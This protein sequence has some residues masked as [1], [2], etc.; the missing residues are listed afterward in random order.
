MK[1]NKTL[2][3]SLLSLILVLSVA[4]ACFS[5]ACGKKNGNEGG[6]TP[7]PVD[8]P[9][10]TEYTD[11]E[12]TLLDFESPK[13]LY[14]V[15][16]YIEDI[17]DLYGKITV[18][19][20]AEQARSGKGFLKFAYVSGKN[21]SLVFYPAHSDYPDIPVERLASF[22]I[23]VFSTAEKDKK[24][25]LSIVSGSTAVYS[26]QKEFKP[27]WNDY[28]FELDPVL[29]KFRSDEI[30]AFCVGTEGGDA[31]DFYFD[32]WT[33]TIGEKE[34]TE[35][36][37]TA[38]SFAEEADKLKTGTPSEDTL[39]KAYGYYGKLDEACRSAVESY[40]EDYVKAVAKFLDAKSWDDAS[41]WAHF[42]EKYGILQLGETEGATYEYG[43]DAFGNGKGGTSLTFGGFE[44]H[45]ESSEK[46]PASAES[47]FNVGITTSTI[48]TDRYDY[49]EFDI[50]NE[51]DKDV[52]LC[53]N[54][55]SNAVTIPAGKTVKANLPATDFVE[56]GNVIT[57]TFNYVEGQ[58]E[59]AKIILST[60]SAKTVSRDNI[61][62]SAL[63]GGKYGGSGNVTISQS[64]GKYVADIK[65]AEAKISVNK[66]YN[67]INVSQ[68][69][70][71]S[72]V[73]DKT[74]TLS[75]YNANDELV[76]RYDV[77]E[78]ASVIIL[79]EDEYE[80]L[81]Y[82]K[83]SVAC[84]ITLSDMLLSRAVNNDYTEIILKNDYVVGAEELTA[85]N[86]R[87]AVYFLSSFESMVAYKQNRMKSDNADVYAD[88]TA[89]ATK[90]SEIFK[91]IV[92]K[93]EAGTASETEGMLIL[94]LSGTYS[95]LKTVTPFTD[96][97]RYAIDDAK[98][99]TLL[100]YKYTV[101]DFNDPM[102]TSKFVAD[103]K[104]V[105]WSGSIAVE[106]FD[107]GKKL[108]IGVR[109][110]LP[111]G[112]RNARRI[113]MTYDISS[114][115]SVLSG[116]DYI[117]WRFY[118]ANSEDATLFFINYGWSGTVA[119]F[120]LKANRWTEIKL[121]INDFKSAVS[122]V[123]FPTDPGDKFYVDNAYACSAEYVQ[124][125]IDAIPDAKDITAY[126][127]DT[128]NFA[129]TEY[130]KLSSLAK[131]K[132]DVTRLTQAE[133]ILARLPY[134]VFDMSK[135]GVLD[136]FTHPT[137]IPSYL[138]DGDFSIEEDETY[139]KVL[140]VNTTG[141]TG[142]SPVLYLGYLLDEG[143]SA[144]DYVTFS[145][146]NPRSVEVR[147]C[148]ITRGWGKLYYSTQ[149]KAN[150]WTEVTVPVSALVSGGYF[151]FAEVLKNETLSF[152]I[153]DMVA[154]GSSSVQY[155]ID[156]LP[157]AD[158]VVA[159]DVDAIMSARIYYDKL[160]DGAKS[161]VNADKLV[162]CENALKNID[163]KIFDMSVDGVL[164]KFVN[165][166]EFYDWAG[167]FSIET[168]ATY[169]K[170]LSINT[171]GTPKA[172]V[173][174]GY[175]LAGVDLSN[176]T[177]VTF[178]VYNPASKNLTFA[179]IKRGYEKA[180]AK[181]TLLPGEW[182]EI[183]MSATDFKSA[184]YFYFADLRDAPENAKILITDVIAHN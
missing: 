27:G 50:K 163:Y 100:K 87:E 155:M 124:S 95:L 121:A 30:I 140:S 6:D 166:N 9:E 132:V 76:T 42:S 181:A 70:L 179:V 104:W 113:W 161:K 17:L 136:K 62:E 137:D 115:S 178:K 130:E 35:V 172:V 108:A 7:G 157:D 79:S 169:G 109:K 54:G 154:Y 14:C 65:D 38:L 37:K 52:S 123:I 152:R 53:V 83:T 18:E 173:Y 138:W 1:R 171:S 159:S 41:A 36:Q 101:F 110:V 55:S 131:K 81:S 111:D 170:V 78:T 105:E 92:S 180:Y 13:D 73:S 48:V 133:E 71:T 67:D 116:Y 114:I 97:E 77:S 151:Y 40:Y 90:I 176:Y 147:F 167:T 80:A 149:L 19:E 127:R 63:D 68:N 156:G 177:S 102:A 82:I 126:D 46:A 39:L 182:T 59:N 119:T 56:S 85:D 103:I 94:D 21:P 144:Y 20:N 158:K 153:T 129:R 184:G 118:N 125:A 72:V 60:L 51:S 44:D 120:T 5:F 183:T 75:L 58:T 11:G 57:F 165:P 106:D 28:V 66:K 148:V 64:N 32:K 91:K 26:E 15:R 99:S 150:G 16:P 112:D 3:I 93:L 69:T 33:A 10:K 49:V 160:S 25:T 88:L 142:S 146:Y 43:A 24:A 22:G 8:Q 164:S 96:E 84:K 135:E 89:R 98:K 34:L 107:G 4:F 86:A 143:I 47:K 174:V 45:D 145:V 61:Y 162:A 128:V 29:M 134:Y 31:C 141:T 12:Y 2:L 23:S 117:T 175:D 74:V 168:D 122:F 139:G